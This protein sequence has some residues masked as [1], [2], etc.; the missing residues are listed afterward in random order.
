[1]RPFGAI[2]QRVICTESFSN[3]IYYFAISVQST[4]QTSCKE[5]ECWD[6]VSFIAWLNSKIQ[7]PGQTVVQI[8]LEVLWRLSDR[9]GLTGQMNKKKWH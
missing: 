4:F 9:T 5:M 3:I 6:N 7:Y 2:K 1:M 8:L